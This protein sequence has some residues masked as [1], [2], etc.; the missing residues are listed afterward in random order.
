M[1]GLLSTLLVLVYGRQRL[2]RLGRNASKPLVKSLAIAS[3]L[4]RWWR[5]TDPPADKR[6]AVS[7][8]ALTALGLD[9]RVLEPDGAGGFHERQVFDPGM[10]DSLRDD[11]I[12]E[13]D[14]QLDIMQDFAQGGRTWKLFRPDPLTSFRDV[15][16]PI[17]FAVTRGDSGQVEVDLLDVR[18][19]GG[20]GPS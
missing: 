11:A 2:D 8:L 3:E 12:N 17:E 16:E 1:P 7:Q 20:G 19:A 18:S 4:R 14:A 6:A 5:G 10:I 15:D 13:L 9:K